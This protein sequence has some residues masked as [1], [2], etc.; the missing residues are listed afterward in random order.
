MDSEHKRGLINF[1]LAVGPLLMPPSSHWYSHAEQILN[2][3]QFVG[4]N[5]NNK[6]HHL[7]SDTVSLKYALNVAGPDKT[8]GPAN[9]W[10]KTAINQMCNY[11]TGL[12]CSGPELWGPSGVSRSALL[13]IQQFE[14]LNKSEFVSNCSDLFQGTTWATPPK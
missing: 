9:L 7:D 6:A 12:T 11:L 10:C 1:K 5:Q 8:A 14:W 4:L 3:F 2:L 13:V